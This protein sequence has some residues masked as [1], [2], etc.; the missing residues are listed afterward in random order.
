MNGRHRYVSGRADPA[1]LPS[2]AE[3]EEPSRWLARVEPS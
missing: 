2:E 1:Y 3:L